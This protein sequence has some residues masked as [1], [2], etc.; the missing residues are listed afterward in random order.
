M[1][2]DFDFRKD[3]R[4]SSIVSQLRDYYDVEKWDQLCNKHKEEYSLR[5]SEHYATTAEIYQALDELNLP[6]NVLFDLHCIYDILALAESEV[7]GVNT[8]K[9]HF[10]EVG[11]CSSIN[12]TIFICL[13][14]DGLRPFV[15]RSTKVQVGS[16]SIECSHGLLDIPAPATKRILEHG[17][18]VISERLEGELCTPTSAAIIGYYCFSPRFSPYN[19]Y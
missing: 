14:F 4:R 19:Q 1:I 15:A 16:G 6:Q 5:S 13:A 7:H 18:P 11:K 8:E 3:A 9:I 17:I 12:N 10:H 2:L